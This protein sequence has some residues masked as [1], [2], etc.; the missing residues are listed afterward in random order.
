M[1]SWGWNGRAQ[2]WATKTSLAP[3]ASSSETKRGEV[4]KGRRTHVYGE[5]GMQT[6][7]PGRVAASEAYLAAN[8]EVV[9]ID[10]TER[11]DHDSLREEKRAHALADTTE[12]RQ[13]PLKL[14]A[15]LDLVSG[16]D[17]VADVETDAPVGCWLSTGHA[18]IVRWMTDFVNNA[19]EGGKI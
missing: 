19:I 14:V 10:R 2:G 3:F 17:V 1:G 12:G 15:H 13:A 11:R 6:P 4:R 18:A 5:A 16:R 7:R 9:E 8:L